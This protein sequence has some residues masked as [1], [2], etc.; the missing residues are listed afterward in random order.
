MQMNFINPFIIQNEEF[1]MDCVWKF[2]QVQFHQNK[3]N[4]NFQDFTYFFFLIIFLLFKKF[5][6]FPQL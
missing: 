3:L 6:I 2:M 5:T 1:L 4:L